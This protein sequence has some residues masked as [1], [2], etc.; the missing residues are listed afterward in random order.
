MKQPVPGIASSTTASAV[1]GTA[2]ALLYGALAPIVAGR[3]KPG[4]PGYDFEI[5]LASALLAPAFPFLI[6]YAEFFKMWPLRRERKQ[7]PQ[8]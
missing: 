7:S 2:L 3:V 6:L 5:W 4:T 8:L 1:I